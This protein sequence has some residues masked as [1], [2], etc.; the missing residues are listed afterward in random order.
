MKIFIKKIYIT[1]FFFTF[2]LGNS[3]VLAKDNKI[4]YSKENI[5]NYF[6]GIVSI[7]QNHNNEAFKYLNQ[8]RTL[9]NKH[10]EYNVEFIRTLI[11]L[12]KFKKAVD[13]SQEIWNND[14]IFFEADLLLGLDAFLKEDYQKAEKYFERLNRISKYNLFF[15]NF[16]GNI[17]ISWSKA[18]QNQKDESFKFIE[19]IPAPFQHLK[20]I[21]HIFLQCHFDLDSTKQSFKNLINSKDYNFSRYNFFLANYLLS[22]GNKTDAKIIIQNSTKKYNSNLL[23]QQ[24]NL[25]FLNN[26]VKKIEHLFNCKNPKDSL[27]EFFYV[28]ANLYSSEDDYRLSNFYLNISLLLNEKFTPNRTLLAENFYYQKKYD[29]SKDVYVFIKSIGQVYY[30]YASKNIAIILTDEKGKEYSTKALE[31]DFNSLTKIN[32]RHYYE[33]ANFYKDNEFYKESINYYSLALKEIDIDNPLAAKIFDRRG[34][35]YERLDDWENAE[36]DLLKSLEIKPDQPHVLNY[37]AYTWID[38]G[39]HLDEGLEMLKKAVQL[40]KN[41]GYITD[42]LGW[43]YYA[44]KDYNEA[45]YFLQKAVELLPSDPIINDHYAD[46]LWMLNKNIQARYIWKNILKSDVAEVKLKEKIKKKMI[47]GITK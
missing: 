29:E 5:S 24:A 3:T 12:G 35:S 40:R 30:W 19:K 28:I 21:Q 20:E 39:I 16:I 4:K 36:K 2:L 9:K 34:T 23:L 42:S 26:K 27:A 15:D 41:D 44:K 6:L 38:K 25:F 33:L 13:F 32:P 37:L 8:I 17:L 14:E 11:S 47:F 45:N 31:K 43:A 10:S 18:A 46:S 7:K 1:I 22:R